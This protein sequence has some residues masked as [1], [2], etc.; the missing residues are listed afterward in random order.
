MTQPQKPAGEN[1]LYNILFN[2]ALPALILYKLSGPERLG[3]LNAL[4]V[5]LCFPVGYGIWDFVTKKKANAISILGFVSIL[6]TGTFGLM[7]L[8]G[9][10]FAVKEAS[11]PTL[12]GVAVVVSLKTR[13]PLVKTLLYNDKVIDVERVDTELKARGT[14]T[15]F[16]RLLLVTTW[17]LAGSF[18]L[19]AVLNFALAIY[20]L[21]SPAGTEEFNQE[22]GKMTAMSYP[23]IVLPCMAVTMF[24]LWRL[25]HGIK[26]LTGLDLDTIFKGSQPGAKT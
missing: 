25:L 20:L 6:L 11:I 23:V 5:A 10:W 18:A 1:P 17:L 22:L 15:N 12:M 8:D 24:A 9:I 26:K 19:S 13:Y 4:V 14:E 21:K 16:E 3:P 7:Q 2:I